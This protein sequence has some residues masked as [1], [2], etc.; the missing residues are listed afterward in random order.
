M[1]TM[2]SQ[3]IGEFPAQRASYAENVSI[4]W[5]HHE[6]TCSLNQQPLPVHLFPVVMGCLRSGVFNRRAWSWSTFYHRRLTY[7][8]VGM[9]TPAMPMLYNCKGRA[10]Y[11]FGECLFSIKG[12]LNEVLMTMCYCVVIDYSGCK[13]H[14]GAGTGTLSTVYQCN[15]GS[16]LVVRRSC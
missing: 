9:L 2:A 11:M 3:I 1:T 12:F 16:T 4:W 10:I 14:R 8:L 6:L 15:P 13:C 5:R 7:K